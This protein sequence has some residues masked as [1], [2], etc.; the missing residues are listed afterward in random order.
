MFDALALKAPLASPTFTGTVNGITKSMV[1]LG[2]V[3]NTADV[4]KAV[5][6]AAALI[7]S[8]VAGESLSAATLYAMRYG[9]AADAGFVAG[10]MYKADP[11][12]TSADNFDVIGVCLTV[13][14]VS[15][16]GAISL[17]NNGNLTATA[18]GLTV[19][20]PIWLGASGAITQTAPTGA[21][22]SASVKLGTVKDAN[23]LRIK[24]QIM[25][26]G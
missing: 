11:D 22:L 5:A 17:V 16:A 9:R 4:N 3:D 1:G 7:T 26:A 19:G 13:G 14:A 2:N 10:R 21:A 18:H 6:S 12:S 15:A 24:V 8:E 23:T 25:S 20:E